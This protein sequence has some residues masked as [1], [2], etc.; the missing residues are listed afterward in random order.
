MNWQVHHYQLEEMAL[1]LQGQ[2]QC[3]QGGGEEGAQPE[4]AQQHLLV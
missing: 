4:G 3:L 2:L 1:L